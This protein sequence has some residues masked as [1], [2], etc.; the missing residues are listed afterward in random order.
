MGVWETLVIFFL[1]F[2][3]DFQETDVYEPNIATCLVISILSL[4]YFA[5]CAD[6]FGCFLFG[7]WN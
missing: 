2:D 5:R 6:E 1:E 7:S 4:W 3:P